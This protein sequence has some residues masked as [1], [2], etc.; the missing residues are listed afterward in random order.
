MAAVIKRYRMFIALVVINSVILLLGFDQGYIAFEAAA[1]N[2]KEMLLVLPPIFILMGL[3]DVWVKRETMIVWMGDKSGLKGMLLAFLLGSAAAGPLYA[4]FPITYMMAKKGVSVT[5]ILV[6]LGAWSTLKIPM[7]LFEFSNLGIKF[8]L[9][10]MLFNIVAI[11]LLS[12][13]VN[14]LMTERD[15]RAFQEAIAKNDALST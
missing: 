8:T 14:R 12:W 3:L 6:F 15:L 7:L 9:I 10:R 5:N 2:L 4:A 1:M 11:A 13:L